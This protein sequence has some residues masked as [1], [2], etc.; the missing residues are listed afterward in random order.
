MDVFE[1][2]GLANLTTPLDFNR[3]LEHLTIL[4][5]KEMQQKALLGFSTL[6]IGTSTKCTIYAKVGSKTGDSNNAHVKFRK[7]FIENM[8][9]MGCDCSDSMHY[10]DDTIQIWW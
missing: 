2:K 8:R 4:V 5:G 9:A 1:A 10:S 6:T 3:R 7:K